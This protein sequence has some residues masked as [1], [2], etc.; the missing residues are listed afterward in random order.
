MQNIDDR[1][2]A[3][4]VDLDAEQQSLIGN[5]QRL[6]LIGAR[7]DQAHYASDRAAYISERVAKR[8]RVASLRIRSASIDA[9]LSD[10]RREP[11]Q[12]RD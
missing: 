9:A 11:A 4:L 7:L 2:K 1:L 3:L 8:C 12:Q 6:L 10:A 5:R